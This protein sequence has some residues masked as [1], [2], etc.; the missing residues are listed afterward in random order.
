M[1]SEELG[2]LNMLEG[3]IIKESIAVSR[4]EGHMNFLLSHDSGR[5]KVPVMVIVPP[6]K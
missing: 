6:M 2:K 4:R 1:S 5:N 3:P